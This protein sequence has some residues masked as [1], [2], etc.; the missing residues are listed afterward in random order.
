MYFFL[1]LL[2][3]F[4]QHHRTEFPYPEKHK[5]YILQILHNIALAQAL[6]FPSQLHFFEKKSSESLVSFRKSCNFAL[7]KRNQLTKVSWRDGRVVDYSSLENCR[8][9]R[10]RGFESLSLRLKGVNLQTMRFTP[11]SFSFVQTFTA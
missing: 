10:Y 1:Q 2:S 5:N 3:K 7:V 9:E 4:S 6:K 11:F 8:T